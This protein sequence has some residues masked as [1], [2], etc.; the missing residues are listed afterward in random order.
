M[1]SDPKTLSQQRFGQ[2]AQSYVTSAPHAQGSDLDRL[3]EI[4]QPQ[5]DWQALDVATGG[6]HTAL[7]FAPHVA[8]VVASD[9]TPNMLEAARAFITGQ[10]EA[11]VSYELADAE[12]L[13]FEDERFDLVTCRIAPHHFADA[14]GFVREAARVLAPGG[15]LL[16]EDH[17]LPD[18]AEAAPVVEAYEKLRDPSHH[19][20]YSEAEWRA[21]FARAGLAVTHTERVEKRLGFVD[22]VER[23]GCA[24]EVVAELVRMLREASPAVAAWLDPRDVG[25]PQATFASHHLI[26]AG[27]KEAR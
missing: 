23:Q 12:Q 4:A 11:N 25:A 21:M 10:G 2:F 17:L 3:L 22:W 20:A 15:R 14:A 18:A 26:I 16:V 24:P 8:W 7:K 6:G 19:R 13:P 5:A 9:I 1:A 27:Q